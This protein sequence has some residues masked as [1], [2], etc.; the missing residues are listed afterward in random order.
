MG[1]A[2]DIISLSVVMSLCAI[3]LTICAAWTVVTVDLILGIDL[4]GKISG[5]FR[6]RKAEENQTWENPTC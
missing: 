6:K 1:I 3:G 4:A 2:A 5:F